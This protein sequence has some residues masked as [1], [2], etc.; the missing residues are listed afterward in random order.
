MFL[1]IQ[2][3]E[4]TIVSNGI[5]LFSHLATSSEIRC[6]LHWKL[7]STPVATGV[8]H[9]C[10]QVCC[11]LG[12]EPLAQRSAS[13]AM[14][15]CVLTPRAGVERRAPRGGGG[16]WRALQHQQGRPGAG[17]GPAGRHLLLQ[18]PVQR[19]LP[20]QDVGGGPGPEAGV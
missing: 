5:L 7:S 14:L 16:P 9:T 15:M 3:L 12:I 13:T 6:R 19:R 18:Q 8:Q 17:P 11:A 2:I 10:S 20:V 1:Y 4:F